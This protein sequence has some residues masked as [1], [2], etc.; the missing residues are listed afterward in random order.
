M[1]FFSVIV[2]EKKTRLFTPNYA[3]TC[4][5]IQR[6]LFVR[7]NYCKQMGTFFFLAWKHMLLHSTV[8]L[9]INRAL[10]DRRRTYRG[11]LCR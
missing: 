1:P 2:I 7:R 6:D 9:P 4:F 5:F 10:R 8:S 3:G 11:K